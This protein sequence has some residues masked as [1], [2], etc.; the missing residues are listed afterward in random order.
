[1][2][3]VRSAVLRSTRDFSCSRW[4]RFELTDGQPLAFRGGQYV[5][6]DTGLVL[7]DGRPRRRAYSMLSPDSEPHSFELGV[8]RLAGGAGSELLNQ[9][10][11]GSELRFTGPWGKLHVPEDLATRPGPIWMIATDSGASAAIGMLRSQALQPYLSRVQLWHFRTH[12]DAYLSDAFMSETLGCLADLRSEPLASVQAPLRTME[13]ER[14]IEERLSRAGEL[15]AQVYVTGDGILA[16]QSK[17]QLL[18]AG[19]PELHMQSE[20]FF[21]HEKTVKLAPALAP[22]PI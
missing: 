13:L 5:I 12:P 7:P 4:L 14:W 22:E 19:L 2:N 9:L 3:E 18:A 15:P 20:S 10:A 11:E 1:M 16:R 17:Q 21:N 6:V 8:F